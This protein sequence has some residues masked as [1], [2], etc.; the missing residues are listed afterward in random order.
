MIEPH[1]L[2]NAGDA[3]LATV[4][5]GL[6]G[7]AKTVSSGVK[8]VSSRTCAAQGRAGLWENWAGLWICAQQVPVNMSGFLRA[9]LWICCG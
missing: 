9:T 6:R 5:G 8:M 7:Q 2:T 4:S 1:R 3:A